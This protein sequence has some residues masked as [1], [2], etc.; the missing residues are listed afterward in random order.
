MDSSV[1]FLPL[2]KRL[3]AQVM[4]LGGE[5]GLLAQGFETIKL[6]SQPDA[7]HGKAFLYKGLMEAV[8]IVV[9]LA[10][11]EFVQLVAE[12]F[13]THNFFVHIFH[14]F[15][16]FKSAYKKSRDVALSS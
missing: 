2:N 6:I 11:V 15:I 4:F 16:Q 3:V 8:T 5:I 13:M 12:H 10:F 14:P 1:T 7:G 9:V